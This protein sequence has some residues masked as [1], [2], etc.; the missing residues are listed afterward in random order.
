MVGWQVGIVCIGKS[1]WLKTMN[2][3]TIK[4]RTHNQQ[5]FFRRAL[6]KTR[7]KLGLANMGDYTEKSVKPKT[8][9]CHS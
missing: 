6:K 9:F 1:I 3:N 8:K 7:M 2:V 4:E 5:F